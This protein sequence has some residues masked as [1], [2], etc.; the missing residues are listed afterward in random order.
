MKKPK[1]H[2]AIA[3]IE[4]S[5]PLVLTEIENDSQMQAYL[6]DRLDERWVAVQPQAVPEIL[7]RLK[8]LGHLPKVKGAR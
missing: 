7:K 3:L 8:A 2:E 5:D 1:C 6:G 4:V